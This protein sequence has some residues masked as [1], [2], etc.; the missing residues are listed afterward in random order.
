MNKNPLQKIMID[1][2]NIK[3]EMQRNP[4]GS[5]RDTSNLS[6]LS[7]SKVGDAWYV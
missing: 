5:K 2:A 3:I 6:H 1:I 4:S 7:I